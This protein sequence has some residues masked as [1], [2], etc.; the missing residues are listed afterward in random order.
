MMSLPD[1]SVQKLF[2]VKKDNII[3]QKINFQI[4]RSSSNV[5]FHKINSDVAFGFTITMSKCL[6]DL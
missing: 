4:Y 5:N 1:T 3:W 2:L 6:H